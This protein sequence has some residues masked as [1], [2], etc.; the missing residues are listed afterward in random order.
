MKVLKFIIL[1]VI[2][3]AVSCHHLENYWDMTREKG[4]SQQYLDTLRSVTRQ[5]SLYSQLET[6]VHL[7]VTRKNESFLSAYVEEYARIYRLSPEERHRMFNLQQAILT[8]FDEYF[9]F[10]AM[11]DREANDFDK[12]KSI[13]GIFLLTEDGKSVKPVEVRRIEKVTPLLEQFYPYVNKYYGVCY[14]MK[15]PKLATSE[16]SVRLLFTSV[17]GEVTLRWP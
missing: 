15:F 4:V 11:P 9:V 14:L 10:A 2:L 12:P 5:G 13:W 3:L 7:T 17:L 1:S 6:K 16:R 8:D